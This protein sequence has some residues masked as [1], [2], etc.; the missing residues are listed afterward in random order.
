VCHHE[1]DAVAC[2]LLPA[3]KTI[4]SVVREGGD[5]FSEGLLATSHRVSPLTLACL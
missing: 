3:R 5:G 2:R 1:N 4:V